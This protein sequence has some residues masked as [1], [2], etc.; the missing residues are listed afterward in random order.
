[1]VAWS[2]FISEKYKQA[3]CKISNHYPHKVDTILK[4]RCPVIIHTAIYIYY[5]YS[6]NLTRFS[7]TN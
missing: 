2:V 3:L 6:Q 7:K 5:F 1:M 4:I